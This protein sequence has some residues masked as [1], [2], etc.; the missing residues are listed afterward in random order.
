MMGTLDA[1]VIIVMGCDGMHFNDLA[2]AF[3][4]RGASPRSGRNRSV[5]MS[6]PDLVTGELLKK[7]CTGN[8]Y[9]LDAMVQVV[10]EQGP[11][12]EAGAVLRYY[13]GSSGSKTLQEPAL[14][15]SND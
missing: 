6:C 4:D 7:L 3:I 9:V 11:G 15:F 5:T 13:P 12:P 8:R 10:Q 1:A 2:L 14:G